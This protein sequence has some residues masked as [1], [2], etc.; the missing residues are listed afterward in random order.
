MWARVQLLRV[1]PPCP[2]RMLVLWAAS[3]LMGKQLRVGL[4]VLVGIVLMGAIIFVIG[5][6]RQAWSRKVTYRA[7]FGDVAGLKPGAPVRMGGVDVGAVTEVEHGEDVGDAK[8]H[9]LMSMVKSEARRIRVDT[10]ARIVNKGLLG[11]KMVELSVADGRAPE[12]NP[13]LPMKTEEPLDFGKYIAKFES[14]AQKTEKVVENAERATGALA[15]PAFTDDVKGTMQS[16][17]AILDGVAQKDGVAHR[18]IFDPEE[19]KKLDRTLT[20]LDNATANLSSALADA[21]DVTAQIKGGS[22]LAHALVYDSDMT[23][24]AAGAIKE[25]HTDLL[26]IRQGNG[27]IHSFVYGDSDTQHL[28]GNVNAISDDLRVV[29]ANMRAGKGT[30]G[31]LLVDPSVYEDIKSIV[32]NV[33]RNQVLRAL[34]RYSIKADEQKPGAKVEPTAPTAP[35]PK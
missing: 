32:G 19:G 1:A 27:L 31:A 23:N 11:D 29:V 2:A 28:M 13:E 24:N 4:F 10:T 17:R 20:N 21:R 5:D 15:D 9:V 8:I 7:E 35:T 25:V 6:S 18:L 14:I 16:L 30:L 26:A 34:V 33:D 12:Q 3:T 22:G